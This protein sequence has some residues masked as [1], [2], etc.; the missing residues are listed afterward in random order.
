MNGLMRIGII[1]LL[2]TLSGCS[3]IDASEKDLIGSYKV[4]HNFG[5][6]ELTLREDMTF[7][8]R[9]DLKD[10]VGLTN[11]GLW[12]VEKGNPGDAFSGS[13]AKLHGGLMF[14]N[15][16]GDRVPQPI[17]EDISLLIEWVW[18]RVELTFSPDLPGYRKK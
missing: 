11:E 2:L 5:S 13:K 3:H 14:S 10:G 6:E 8:Q 1:A 7:M 18:G 17:R 12:S 15:W 4:D 16:R 9:L